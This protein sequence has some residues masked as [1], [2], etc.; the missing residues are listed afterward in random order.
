MAAAYDKARLETTEI[1]RVKN[2]FIAKLEQ[3]GRLVLYRERKSIQTGDL[4]TMEV[5]SIL[6]IYI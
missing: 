6:R 1:T 4:G 3:A 2:D 5:S